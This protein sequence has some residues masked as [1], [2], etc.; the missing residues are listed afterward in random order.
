MHAAVTW[1]IAAATIGAVVTRPLRTGEW[2]WSVIGAG[3][4]VTAGL[5]SGA[6]AAQAARDG[7]DVYAFLAGMLALAELARVQ[8]AFGWL[9]GVLASGARGNTR[10]LFASSFA[11]AIAVT[12]LLS[13]DGTILLLTPAALALARTARV[14]AAPF[15]YAIAFVA[16]A[17]SFIL[18]ISN[19]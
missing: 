17:A 13:N 6:Q 5:L 7:L 1:A 19:P 3:V 11:G 4:L 16:N 9:A 8:G 12:A 18:P 15:A 14:S 10:S 2:V